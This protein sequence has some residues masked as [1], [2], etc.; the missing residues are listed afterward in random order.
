MT[1]VH[2]PNN[3]ALR[4][5]RL[6]IKNYAAMVRN[7]RREVRLL[8]QAC[9]HARCIRTVETD[10]AGHPYTKWVKRNDPF[11]CGNMQYAA[12]FLQKAQHSPH[13]LVYHAGL[14]Y[15]FLR[16]RPIQFRKDPNCTKWQWFR[17]FVFQHG[18]KAQ[19]DEFLARWADNLPVH[20]RTASVLETHNEGWWAQ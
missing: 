13:E 8:R 9:R 16:D 11:K 4:S 15:N 2:D 6:T 12:D 7:N 20:E 14:A 3:M 10:N 17:D 1:M 18:T 5:L 19:C